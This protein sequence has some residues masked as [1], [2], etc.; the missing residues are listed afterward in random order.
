MCHPFS[1]QAVF[2]FIEMSSGKIKKSLDLL[3]TT[4]DEELRQA[5]MKWLMELVTFA[6]VCFCFVFYNIEFLE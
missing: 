3:C 2:V 6:Q 4:D 1:S 5:K